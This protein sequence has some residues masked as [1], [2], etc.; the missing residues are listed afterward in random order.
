MLGRIDPQKSKRKYKFNGVSGIKPKDLKAL[1]EL[2]AVLQKKLDSPGDP[3]DPMWV[4]G[5][6]AA[7]DAEIAK[8]ERTQSQKSREKKPSVRRPKKR[9]TGDFKSSVL[10]GYCGAGALAY[11]ELRLR[12]CDQKAITEPRPV[13]GR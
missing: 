12:R 2:R 4:K 13:I 11:R 10:G 5:R 3:D 8:K 9:L 7:Y 1:K 6:L